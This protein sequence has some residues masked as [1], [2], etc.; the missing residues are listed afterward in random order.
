MMIQTS[1][2]RCALLKRQLRFFHFL[3]EKD[4]DILPEYFTC[5]QIKAGEV[6]WKEGDVGDFEAFIVEGKIEVKK[7]TEFAGKQVVVGVYS[8]GAIVGEFC[9]VE[10]G[11][12]AVTAVAMED[13]SLLFLTCEN[14]EAL[15]Q[16][17]PVLGGK[18]LKGMLFAVSTRLRKSFER[19]ASIF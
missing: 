8:P 11:P 16:D 17:H 5:G 2:E 14:F 13:S 15:L 12:R 19:L 3:E 9:L 10:K 18:I 1:E 6:L 4:L 7:E